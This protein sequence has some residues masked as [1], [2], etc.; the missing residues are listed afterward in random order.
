ML[1]FSSKNSKNSKGGHFLGICDTKQRLTAVYLMA[2]KN[3]A[4]FL[5]K[6]TKSKVTSCDE[7]VFAGQNVFLGPTTHLPRPE[8]FFESHHLR[9]MHVVHCC[10]QMRF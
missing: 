4:H 5:E 9:L 8:C 3:N 2:G 1:R 10:F 7:C 6:A